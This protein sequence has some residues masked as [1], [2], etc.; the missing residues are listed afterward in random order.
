MNQIII[1]INN[2]YYH[3]IMIKY[4]HLEG[5]KT[6]YTILFII[7]IQQSISI[8]KEM[9]LFIQIIHM[10]VNIFLRNQL[11]KRE[12]QLNYLKNI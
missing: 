4:I 7:V 6:I 2:V 11:R 9:S 10:I 5:L 3:N 8:K 1:I 12:L